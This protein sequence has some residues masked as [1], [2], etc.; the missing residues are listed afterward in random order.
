MKDHL[1][2]LTEANA[3]RLVQCREFLAPVS[4]NTFIRLQQIYEHFPDS[5]F[6]APRL[7]R[8]ADTL[9]F[10]KAKIDAVYGFQQGWFRKS[11]SLY[12]KE[13]FCL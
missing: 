3:F 9:R 4:D 2:F 1:D 5:R 12:G 6:A 8:Q 11:A 7:A 13:F 10:M